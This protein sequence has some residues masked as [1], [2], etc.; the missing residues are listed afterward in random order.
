MKKYPGIRVRHGRACASGAGRRC[1]CKPAYEASAYSARD[2]KKVRRTFSTLAAAK[3]WRADAQSALRRG[4]MRAATPT[5]VREAAEV[6]LDGAK[7][8][9]IRTRGGDTY[10]PSAIRSYEQALRDH[11]LPGLGGSRLGDVRRPDVQ[12]LA[13]RLLAAGLG[14]STVRNAV[15]PLR[16]LYRRALARGEVAV[17]PTAGIELPA[18]RGRRDRIASPA[19]AAALLAAVPEADRALWATALYAG[20][21]YGELAALA[22]E[23]VD[24]QAGVLHVARAWDPKAQQ[25]IAPKSR[26]GERRVPIPAL[27]REHLIA[28][29][30]RSG[31][32]QGLAFP[33][34]RGGPF[35]GWAAQERADK[36]WKAAGLARLTL[37]EARHT[38]A[39][40]MI[41]AGVNA[42]ALS[43]YMGHAAI[44]ITL[45]RYGHLMPGNEGEAAELLDTYLAA[46][47]GAIPGAHAR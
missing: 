14:A 30:L 13:D 8:G 38:F 29:K 41:A 43:T 1:N 3:A 11:V 25:F 45:D 27:L 26:A 39:S 24:L 28:H 19:E 36:A 42:K 34:G 9:L 33:G 15:L 31:H 16:V 40:L 46:A 5:T 21:R 37:H 10:K 22:W 20:L 4:T 44:S 23:Q 7:A 6:W 18:A 32:S 35:D 47:T 2:A 17:N 12:E